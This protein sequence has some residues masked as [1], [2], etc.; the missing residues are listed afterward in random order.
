MLGWKI[1]EL[2]A[3][4]ESI[5]SECSIK[6]E[7]LQKENEKVMNALEAIKSENRTDELSS[8][9]EEKESLIQSLS[10]TI[11]GLTQ[12]KQTIEEKLS[13]L[14]AQIAILQNELTSKSGLSA[15]SQVLS[16]LCFQCSKN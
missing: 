8:L 1:H 10:S 14:E 4:I 12:E 3:T 15:S 16:I 2:T 13:K 5:K 9:L 7:E 11:E 6:Q